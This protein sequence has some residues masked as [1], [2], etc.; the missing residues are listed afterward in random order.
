MEHVRQY[1]ADRPQGKATMSSGR[2]ILD[3]LERMAYR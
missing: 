3:G 1:V 2:M